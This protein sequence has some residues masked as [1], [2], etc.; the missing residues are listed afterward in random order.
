MSG[1]GISYGSSDMCS[2][3]EP[4]TED[5][6]R[7]LK[8]FT[9]ASAFL[10]CC[11]SL[12]IL[13]T[14]WLQRGMRRTLFLHM[15]ASLSVADFLSSLIFIVD[16]LSPT[17]E[18]AMCR[19]DTAAAVDQPVTAGCAIYAAGAQ[20]FGI[21]AVLWTGCLALALH[22]GVLR[23]SKLATHEPHKLLK[24]MAIGVWGFSLS[25][26]LIMAA[27]G[28]LGPTG[29]WCW[30]KLQSWWAGLLFYYLPLIAVF[31]YSMTVYYYTRRTFV[32]MTREASVAGGG[33]GS[34][35]S[36]SALLSVTSR[37]RAFL[38]VY[39]IIH[40]FQ[41]L[42][43]AWD[44]VS[45]THPSYALSL[46]HAIFG[47]LQGMCNAIVYG[48]GPATRR[49]WAKAFPGACGWAAP[50]ENTRP[51]SPRGLEVAPGGGLA[52]DSHSGGQYP[53]AHV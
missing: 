44:V 12:F 51:G 20:L 34:S 2:A 30:V 32:G 49:V 33:D 36:G 25:T 23:R 10:S 8:G 27:A 50:Q 11:G 35:S 29:Q 17:G 24:R 15:I 52:G 41:I 48:W 22:L 4:F 45:P 43:R 5:G 18:L 37:L 46:L 19:N 9:I 47:P 3:G 1:Q 31:F 7:A 53:P 39:A 6:L 42:N 13:T 38:L 26:L 16:G 28:T 21:G 14:W 40:T